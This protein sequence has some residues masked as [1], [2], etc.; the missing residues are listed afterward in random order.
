MDYLDDDQ[1]PD[2]EFSYDII[3]AKLL[4]DIRF[5]NEQITSTLINED[6]KNVIEFFINNYQTYF[7]DLEDIEYEDMFSDE[8]NELD[9]YIVDIMNFLLAN[10]VD[11]NY[12]LNKIIRSDPHIDDKRN[13]T[14][15]TLNFF[16]NNDLNSFIETV[17][18][19][20]IN[21]IYL[22]LLNYNRYSSTISDFVDQ[23]MEEEEILRQERKNIEYESEDELYGSDIE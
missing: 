12:M 17:K 6:L 14:L 11:V 1:E 22:L 20:L 18:Y 2:V 7:E 5:S 10:N 3:I 4:S 23:L 13:Y 8:D 19:P 16:Q 15:Q 21:Y 9:N